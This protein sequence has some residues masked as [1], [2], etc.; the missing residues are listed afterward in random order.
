[1]FVCPRTRGPLRDWR[2]AQAGI[3]Y[4]VVD[5]VPVLVEEPRTFFLTHRKALGGQPDIRQTESPDPVTPHLTPPHLGAPGGLGQWFASLG[6]TGPDAVCAGFGE[7]HAPAGAALDVGCG[8]APM[9]RRMVGQGRVT[10]AFDKSPDAVLIARSVLCGGTAM[11]SIPTHKVGLRKVK[12]P[13][14]PIVHGL[15]FAVADATRPPF[16]AGSFAWVHLGD[17]LDSAAEAVGE[18]LVASAELV[19]PGGILTLHTAFNGRGTPSETK[20]NPEDEL[21]EALDTLG[22]SLVEHADRV[23]HVVRDYDRSFKLRFSYCL[24]ARRR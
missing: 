16:A 21:I 9:A 4:P 23:P 14:T 3:T 17:V 19:A 24:A 10:F 22:F 5:G 12:V 13:F 11:T 2:S 20:P 6:D 18:V 15:S 8:M 1:M 7:R